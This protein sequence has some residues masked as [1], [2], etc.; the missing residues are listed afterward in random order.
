MWVKYDKEWKKTGQHNKYELKLIGRWRPEEGNSAQRA[1][2]TFD[3]FT[4]DTRGDVQKIYFE[5]K[6]LIMTKMMNFTNI[7]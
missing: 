5:E 6:S 2:G 7:F 3:L 4:W 1:I